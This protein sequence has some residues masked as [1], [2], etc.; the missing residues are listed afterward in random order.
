M[1]IILLIVM[2]V[3]MVIGMPVAFSIAIGA[4]IALLSN[5]TVPLMVLPQKMVTGLDSF[6]LL[7]IPLFILAGELMNSGGLTKRLVNMAQAF[8]GHFR[9]SLAQVGILTNIFMSGVSGSG[10]ADA[11]ATGSI[12]IPEMK[13]RGYSKAFA[14]AVMAASGTIG[15]IIPPSI[16]L[17]LYASIANVSIGTI[18]LGGVMPGIL[19]GIG[20]MII[21]WFVAKKRNYEVSPRANFKQIVKALYEGVPALLSPFIIVFGIV[22]GVFTATES[23]VIAVWFA[24]IVGFLVYKE[25]TFKKLAECLKNAMMTTAI[26]ALIIGLSAPFGWIMS[27]ENVAHSLLTFLG[28]LANTPWLVELII[29]GCI[30]ILGMFLDGTPIIILTT[31]ILLPLL[32]SMGVNLVHYGVMLAVN[33]M[34]GSITPPVGTLMY[35]TTRI[36]GCDIAE[37]TKEAWRYMVVLTVCLLLMLFIPQIVLFL[38]GL[39][40]K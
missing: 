17:V 22:T 19:M 25:L 27:W 40:A 1:T 28:S 18:F 3:C 6:S 32:N 30:L 21:T 35:V 39:F 20:L 10:L 24:V 4:L 7:A 36:A 8:V 34:I 15:P 38:P 14:S 31:P 2:L 12:L 13:K 11:A 9:G 23:A 16:P 29:M 26:V 5:G 37:F 33:T